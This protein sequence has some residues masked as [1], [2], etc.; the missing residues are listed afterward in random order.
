[1]W[2]P[3][4]GPYCTFWEYFSFRV[5]NFTENTAYSSHKW[6]KICE[7]IA[8]STEHSGKPTVKR[9]QR[10]QSPQ[11]RENQFLALFGTFFAAGGDQPGPAGVS[12]ILLRS[13]ME[14][15]RQVVRA[16]GAANKDPKTLQSDR[17]GS[18]P[19]LVGTSFDVLLFLSS[20]KNSKNRWNPGHRDTLKTYYE[21]LS[22][23]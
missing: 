20:S 14:I 1:M 6:I 22:E 19:A 3:L 12:Q 9:Q 18:L 16:R 17:D 15:D 21:N 7:W 4:L 2:I 23:L 5:S 10:L 8:E 13:V 11:N